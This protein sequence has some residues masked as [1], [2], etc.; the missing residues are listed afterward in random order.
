MSPPQAQCYCN[1]EDCV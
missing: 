1:V